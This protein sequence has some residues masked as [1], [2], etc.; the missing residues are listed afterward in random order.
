MGFFDAEMLDMLDVYLLETGQLLERADAVLIGA[1][2][3]GQFSADEINEM[4]R[5]MHTMKSSSAMMGLTELSGLAHRLEDLCSIFR[6]EPEKIHGVEQDTFD[7]LFEVTDMIR[8]ELERMK[9]GGVYAGICSKA[10]SQN[11]RAAGE[12]EGQS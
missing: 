11:R 10:E 8:R 7:L 12:D 9:G 5:I 1:E 2:Q 4:F 3:S 6:E